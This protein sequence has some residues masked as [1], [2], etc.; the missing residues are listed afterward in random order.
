MKVSRFARLTLPVLALGLWVQGAW[1][2]TG[3]KVPDLPSPPRRS[4][5][6]PSGPRPSPKPYS[7]SNTTNA[8]ARHFVPDGSHEIDFIDSTNAQAWFSIPVYFEHTYAIEVYVPFNYDANLGITS[9]PITSLAIAMFENDGT[10]NI[11]PSTDEFAYQPNVD[12]Q[13][14]AGGDRIT[15]SNF[16]SDR[17]VRVVVQA[18]CGNT[19][20]AGGIDFHIRVVDLTQTAARWT[21]N[22]YLMLIALNN[23]SRQ[24][25]TG[26][27][28]YYNEAGAFLSFDSY[29][30]AADGS[31]QI[32]HA[33]N[34]MIGGALFGGIRVIPT[35][36]AP[37]T[38]TAHEYNFNTV[39]GNYLQFPFSARQWVTATP[40]Q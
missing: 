39:V 33:A 3:Q 17:F 14:F 11:T 26:Y 7:S 23:S 2:Q 31:V 5:P 10:T 8:S 32:S 29:S 4:V 18:C 24:T 37:G 30:I 27:V 9:L 28:D 20:P 22:G 21:T 40:S 1:A 25:A 38:I 13:G 12:E 16:G 36:G 15:F 6:E 19:P 35:S 34:V